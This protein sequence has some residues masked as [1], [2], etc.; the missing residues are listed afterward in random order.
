MDRKLL[1]G[2][3]M[4]VFLMSF[5][6]GWYGLS[7]VNEKCDSASFLMFRLL[8]V[9]GA[10]MT[11]VCISEIICYK[12]CQEPDEKINTLVFFG[13]SLL[14]LSIMV[15]TGMLIG[16]INSITDDSDKA[17]NFK[18]A[19]AIMMLCMVIVLG[20]SGYQIYLIFKE[21][22]L[23]QSEEYKE[24]VL[25]ER[26]RR[27]KINNAEKTQKEKSTRK[28]RESKQRLVELESE[29]KQLQGQISVNEKQSTKAD[30][31]LKTAEAN[32][33]ENTSISSQPKID[34]VEPK[35]ENKDSDESEA[36]Q[37]PLEKD[38]YY[39]EILK[40]LRLPHDDIKLSDE[41]KQKIDT[42]RNLGQQYTNTENE[43]RLRGKKQKRKLKKKLEDID[44]ELG[45][46]RSDILN[47][48][49]HTI[50]DNMPLLDPVD[51]KPTTK[52]L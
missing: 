9:G 17:Y 4:V 13:S 26:I 12:S 18:I 36:K 30:I 19:G 40:K 3:I 47:I 7:I 33:I 5:C 23:R 24:S 2:A 38:Q 28:E 20:Y 42:F 44:K 1:L 43:T 22:D 48:L 32:R 25:R 39:I 15:L 50:Y 35:K 49:G 45:V 37:D 29:L 31:K 34:P 21:K 27:A 11:T 51:V 6:I 10:M 41:L 14:S 46:V 16:N 52:T 8:I